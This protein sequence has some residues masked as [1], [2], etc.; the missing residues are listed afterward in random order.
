MALVI[1]EKVCEVI[2]FSQGVKEVCQKP[3]DLLDTLGAIKFITKRVLK[4]RFM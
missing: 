4:L 1:V 2:F 3:V